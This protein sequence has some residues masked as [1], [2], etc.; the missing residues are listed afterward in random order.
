MQVTIFAIFAAVAAALPQQVPPPN[1]ENAC[2]C[3]DVSNIQQPVMSCN[4]AQP[5]TDCF[6]AAVA[7]PA[8]APTVYINGFNAAPAK[9]QAPRSS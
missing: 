4:L 6:C 3:C 2:C 9:T 5:K 1:A 7:C 8:D